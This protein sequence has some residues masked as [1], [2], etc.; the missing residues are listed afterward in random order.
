[1]ILD[2][3][4]NITC[5]LFRIKEVTSNSNCHGTGAGGLFH[6]RLKVYMD[7]KYGKTRMDSKEVLPRMR[8][9]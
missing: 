7:T 5:S 3:E 1:M 9:L 8:I 2:L 6:G 4:V